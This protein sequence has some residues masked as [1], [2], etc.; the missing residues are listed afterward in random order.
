MDVRFYNSIL[1]G[2]AISS[3][4]ILTNICIKLASA[5]LSLTSDSSLPVLAGICLMGWAI[6]L[7]I[8][9]GTGYIAAHVSRDSILDKK[10]AGSVA[11]VAG[12]TLGIALEAD[13]LLIQMIIPALT[14][15]LNNSTA[16]SLIISLVTGTIF[17]VVAIL[18]Y[19]AIASY[20]GQTY[21]SRNL[22]NKD[23]SA[24]AHLQQE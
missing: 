21:F 23:Q 8:C 5:Q 9:G 3:I 19:S 14:N 16:I 24:N 11:S 1:V 10:D 2:I 13:R 12:G 7:L 4:L 6:T 17:A 15:P 22:K 18:I 20:G